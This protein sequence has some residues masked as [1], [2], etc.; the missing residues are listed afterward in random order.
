MNN[1]YYKIGIDFDNTIIGY[2]CIFHKIALKRALIHSN[3]IQSKKHIRDRLRALPNGD[4]EWQKMQAVVYG[5]RIVEGKIIEGVKRFFE[6]CKQNSLKVYIISHKTE[7]AN[8]DE[9]RTNLRSAALGWLK[10][11]KFFDADGLNLSQNDIFFESTRLEKIERIR[12]LKC[13]H[14]IDDLEETFLEEMFPTNVEQ[15]LYNPCQDH[16]SLTNAKVFSNWWQISDYFFGTKGDVQNTKLTSLFSRLLDH[17]I[18]SIEKL[19]EGRNSKVY[20]LTCENSNQYAAKLYFR[21]DLDKRNRTG[22]EFYSLKFL[23]ENGVKCIPQPIAV[24]MD[25]KC[26]VYEL[27]DG[28]MISSHEVTNDNIDSAVQFLAKL[29][30]LKD[31]KH[32]TNLPLASEACFS[33][34]AIVQNIEHRLRRLTALQNY[35]PQYA[36][37]H[38][39][40]M[41]D[42]TPLFDEVTKWC[43]SSLNQAGMSFVVELPYEERTLSPSDFGFHNILRRSD[44]RIVFVDF[45]YFGWDDPAK[46]ISDFLIHPAMSLSEQLKQRFV[47]E[48]FVRFE[49]Y[50]KLP[51]RVE[52][53]CPLFG[54]KWCLIILNEF[55]PEPWLRR[56][57][58]SDVDLDKESLRAKQLSK[59]KQMLSKLRSEYEHFPYD[60]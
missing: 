24:D 16:S 48:I 21:H 53:V 37:L 33:V 50:N 49:N 51:Q 1:A 14:F 44:G 60:S 39:F 58:A 9:A 32:S 31:V 42:F 12:Q 23:W 15:I 3:T 25:H 11:N 27:I 19:G 34:R 28:T 4:I 36:A 52:I 26:A 41:N 38:E 55:L 46:M 17:N 57:F 7:F 5:P 10:K 30:E 47:E 35:E 18:T 40:L 43:E 45:E 29:N 54:L 59:A 13:T 20:R 56:N 22:I 8:F 2:D 6:L